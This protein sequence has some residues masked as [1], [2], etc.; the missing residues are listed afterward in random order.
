MEST[1]RQFIG[2]AAAVAAAILTPA[3]VTAGALANWR[4]P[5]DLQRRMYAATLSI[6][7]SKI[8]G[9]LGDPNF[10]KPFTDAAFSRNIFYW[11]TCFIA[12]YAKYHLDTLPIVNA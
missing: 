10:S 8:R 6:A 5:E 12:T 3:A 7:Q 2:Q 4:V 11:D 9:G 1:K